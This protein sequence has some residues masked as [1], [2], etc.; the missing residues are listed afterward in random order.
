MDRSVR[1]DDAIFDEHPKPPVKEI[2]G[3][4]RFLH[5]LLARV[6]SVFP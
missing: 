4:T 1:I 6:L 3:E 5:K 2:L